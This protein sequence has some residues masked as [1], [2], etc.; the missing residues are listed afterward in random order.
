MS[1]RTTVRRAAAAL[2]DSTVLHGFARAGLLFNGVLHVII[3]SLAFAIAFGEHPAASHEGALA[4][5]SRGPIGG[6]LLWATVAGFCGLAFF[7]L[8]TLALVRGL[9]KRSWVAR[10][11]PFGR[12]LA[13]V[14]LGWVALRFATG[15]SPEGSE[16]QSISAD[17][18]SRP[19]GVVVV[20]AIGAGILIGG[21]S[22][23]TIGIRQRF[24]ND[25]GSQRPVV[26]RAARIFGTVGYI[27]KG[28]AFI[29]IGVLFSIAAISADPEEAG[30]LD[31]ALESLR[32]LPS[33]NVVLS[34]V[35]LG[36]I[37]F[38]LYCFIRTKYERLERPRR[39]L[40]RS[41]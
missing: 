31:G 22:F 40:F 37:L 5:L 38:G 6:P 1:R 30:G 29:T 10:S 20:F 14:A 19:G 18:L 27:A 32:R 13:Y 21:V 35:A 12:T 9:D 17:L 3:G 7:Q 28:I 33:G 41:R 2:Q 4:Q 26:N 8:L 16:A 24:L 15:N 11:K 25:I 34:I 39:P 36:L 23:V